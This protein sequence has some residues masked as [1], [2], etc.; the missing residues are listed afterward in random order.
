MQQRGIAPNLPVP[1]GDDG[2]YVASPSL[3]LELGV[4]GH[5][6][7]EFIQRDGRLRHQ[8]F[9]VFE[10]SQRQDAP[11]QF[12]QAARFQLDSVEHVHALRISALASQP[13][14]HI[15]ARRNRNSWEMSFNNRDCAFSKVSIRSAIAS[16]SR[17][18]PATSSRRVLDGAPVRA[19]RSPA[20]S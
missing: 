3:R 15:G 19:V 5:I 8:L 7:D 11:N 13:K 12:V 6:R 10:P 4:L 20:A 14:G 9:A 18:R 16:K 17:M 1:V 2:A